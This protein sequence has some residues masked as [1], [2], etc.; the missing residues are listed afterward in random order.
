MNVVVEG[1]DLPGIRCGPNPE[2]G[3]YENIHVGL[4]VRGARAEGLAVDG[5][6]WKVADLFPGDADETRWEFEV[7]VKGAGSEL[8]FGGPFVRG[9][10]GDRHIFLAW[11]E[12]SDGGIR[13]DLFRG[14]K[15]RLDRIEPQLVKQASAPRVLVGRVGMT[16]DKGHPG[17]AT[18]GPNALTWTV[19]R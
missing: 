7:L 1:F 15:L 11:G 5:R 6:P 19:R 2:G 18:L 12:L 8:D 3:W 9:N 4:A 14:S 16:N 10:K 13:F 17:C